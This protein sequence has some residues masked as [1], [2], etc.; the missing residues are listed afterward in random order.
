MNFSPKEG[1]DKQILTPNQVAEMLMVSPAAVRQ[2]ASKGELS[3][4]T[5]P[6]GHRRFKMADVVAFAQNRGMSL[7]S[8][9]EDISVLIVDDDVQYANYLKEII[10]LHDERIKVRV[11][12]DGFEAG[13][14]V[15]S[16]RPDLIYLDLRMPTMDG[17]ETCKRLKEDPETESIRI[18]CMT[19]YEEAKDEEVV[20]GYGA[21]AC[22]SK[23]VD[24]DIVTAY[25]DKLLDSLQL[26]S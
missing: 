2:W 18:I 5:T 25:L 26:A 22:L 8:H 13:K 12:H 10:S 23:P 20:L 14:L 24:E 9:L 19:G 4:L 16:F 7:H 6:G 21:E 11:A 1:K 15:Q 3:A 17:F